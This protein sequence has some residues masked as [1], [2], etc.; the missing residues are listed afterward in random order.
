MVK[1]MNYAKEAGYKSKIAA[2]DY[3]DFF[4][5][6]VLEEVAFCLLEGAE[7]NDDAL[8]KTRRKALINFIIAHGL[9]IREIDK[10]A[11][12]GALGYLYENKRGVAGKR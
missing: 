7:V 11:E 1:I 9:T 6:E 2:R 5:D 10:I 4:C 12:R 8:G 3:L